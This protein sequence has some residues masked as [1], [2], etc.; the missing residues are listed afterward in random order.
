[1][2]TKRITINSIVYDREPVQKEWYDRKGDTHSYDP[3]ASWEMKK[4]KT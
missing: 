1:M 2:Y 4:I 3:Q